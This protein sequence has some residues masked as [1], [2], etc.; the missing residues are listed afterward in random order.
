MF[1]L[2]QVRCSRGCDVRY[3]LQRPPLL[4]A[5]PHETR[6]LTRQHRNQHPKRGVACTPCHHGHGAQHTTKARQ[7]SRSTPKPKPKPA[8]LLSHRRRRSPSVPARRGSACPGWGHGG[9]PRSCNVI[10][11]MVDARGEG[12]RNGT[13]GEM[14][15]HIIRPEVR[16]LRRQHWGH[17]ILSFSMVLRPPPVG[18]VG[19]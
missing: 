14:R 5:A 17:F 7:R 2:S 1:S 15:V 8:P 3:R 13:D 11:S 16:G 19:A 4:Q 12:A 10:C 6:L 18:L 9:E